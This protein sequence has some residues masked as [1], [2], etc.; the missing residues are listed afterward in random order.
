MNDAWSQ[1]G[2][3]TGGLDWY[4][5][6]VFNGDV[7]VKSFSDKYPPKVYEKVSVDENIPV[8]VIWGMGDTAFDNEY[9]LSQLPKYTPAKNL[10]IKKYPGVSHWIAQEKPEEVGADMATFIGK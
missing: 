10:Q 3:T 5:C 4:W 9:H 6:N 2:A 7:N 1:P 8:L